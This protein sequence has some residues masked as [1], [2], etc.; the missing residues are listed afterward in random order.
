MMAAAVTPDDE[1]KTNK[2]KIANTKS[3]TPDDK[4]KTN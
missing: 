4:L 2:N 1:L 3:V